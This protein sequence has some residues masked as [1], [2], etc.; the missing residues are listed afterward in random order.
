MD[1]MDLTDAVVPLLI[2]AGLGAAVGIER[3]S[4][5]KPAGLRTH[6]MV[7]LGSATFTNL[8]L[9]LVSDAS[10]PSRIVMGIATGLG[11]LGAG[12]IIRSG[13]EVH[14]ITTASGIWVVGAAGAC[15]GAS[16]YDIA[17][18]AVIL[19]LVILALLGRVETT[20]PR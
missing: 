19:S 13:G 15:C 12:S 6:M 17:V 1:W 18:V 4:W 10:D 20:P 2:A 14:G 8:A 7:A 5:K 16:Q 3:E 9:R 11:F